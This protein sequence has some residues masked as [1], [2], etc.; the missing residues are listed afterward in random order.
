MEW[1]FKYSYSLDNEY[2]SCDYDSVHEALADAKVE[3]AQEYPAGDIDKV[4][5]G[6]VCEFKPTVNAEA[7]IEAI[8]N[9]AD[10]E[11]D[12]ASLDYLEDVGIADLNKLEVMLTETFNKWA[13]ETGNEPNF[14]TVENIK[15]YSL[16]EGKQCG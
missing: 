12:E 16:E 5:I 10:D 13:A 1:N 14:F 3:A 9:D 2:F 4:Y 6:D 7:V 15:E 8:Q 11:A